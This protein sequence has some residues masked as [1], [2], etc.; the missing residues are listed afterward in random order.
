MSPSLPLPLPRS[1]TCKTLPHHYLIRTLLWPH[2]SNNVCDTSVIYTLLIIGLKLGLLLKLALKPLPSKKGSSRKLIIV[3]ACFQKRFWKTNSLTH[4]DRL[5]L[6]RNVAQS[7]RFSCP[8]LHSNLAWARFSYSIMFY[9]F[10]VFSSL[11]PR[12][13][14]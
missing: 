1:T 6:T 10:T 3:V 12:P 2:P 7:N 8:I 13:I 11:V 4:S 9:V 5:H 14:F